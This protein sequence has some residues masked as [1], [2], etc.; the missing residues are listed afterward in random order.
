VFCEP[1]LHMSFLQKWKKWEL[2]VP[3]AGH[4]CVCG[5]VRVWRSEDSLQELALFFSH[6]RP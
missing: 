5:R 6:G 4:L 2:A 3:C 1:L